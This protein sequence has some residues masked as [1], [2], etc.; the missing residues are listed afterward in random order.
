M[1]AIAVIVHLMCRPELTKQQPELSLHFAADESCLCLFGQRL[2]GFGVA[3]CSYTMHT[4]RLQS[5]CMLSLVLLTAGYIYILPSLLLQLCHVLVVWWFV[6]CCNW[7][8]LVAES[9][10]C[11]D[12]VLDTALVAHSVCGCCI[13]CSAWSVGGLTWQ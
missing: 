9:L 7:Y 10:I 3:T 1:A 6:G 13:R 2:A 4:Y 5:L 12:V 11:I 8:S